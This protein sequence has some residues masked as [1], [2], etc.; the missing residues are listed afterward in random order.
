MTLS[1][2]SI[3]FP[4]VLRCLL[5][6][7]KRLSRDF[8]DGEGIDFPQIVFDAIK[9]NSAFLRMLQQI[10]PL[11]ERPWFLPWFSEYLHTIRSL[12]AFPEV[13]A[14][15]AD[16]LCGE[17]QHERFKGARPLIIETAM[18]VCVLYEQL[19]C[20]THPIEIALSVRLPQG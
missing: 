12:P 2:F 5:L 15:I 11:E 9:D 6:L 1:C 10:N 16:F 3:E 17:T 14:R 4:E 18:P 7:L 19:I 13:L 8:W 20:N